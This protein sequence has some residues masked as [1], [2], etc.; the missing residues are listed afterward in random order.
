[1][2]FEQELKYFRE[3]CWPGS[4]EAVTEIL[5]E[6][7]RR[8]DTS[9]NSVLFWVTNMLRLRQEYGEN[10]LGNLLGLPYLQW[11]WRLEHACQAVAPI[12]QHHET[13]QELREWIAKMTAAMREV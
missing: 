4:A 12:F 5:N 8:P 2:T 11:L 10:V 3:E 13:S 6:W 1:M 7:D 9:S